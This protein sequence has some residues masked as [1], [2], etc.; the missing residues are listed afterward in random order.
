MPLLIILLCC[1]YGLAQL[2]APLF[3]TP[4]LISTTVTALHCCA[5]A[6]PLRPT[7]APTQSYLSPPPGRYPC[8][9]LCLGQ[10]RGPHPLSCSLLAH[11]C[12]CYH[13][14]D[15]STRAL[16][17]TPCQHPSTQW[18]PM[19]HATLLAA[20]HACRAGWTTHGPPHA[21]GATRGSHAAP[22][23]PIRRSPSAQA[24]TGLLGCL[25]SSPPSMRSCL[26]AA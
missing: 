19:G 23:W 6:T 1:S 20:V 17:K 8:M 3:N 18:R 16:A 26:P 22:S 21:T 12:H 2:N 15:R 10:R 7:I 11:I 5:S 13:T 9:C 24:N 14:A 4:N 25:G